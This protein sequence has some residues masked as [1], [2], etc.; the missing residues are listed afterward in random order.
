MHSPRLGAHI[1]LLGSALFV[2]LVSI[3][4]ESPLST[5]SG[6][7]FT[8]PPEFRS[9]WRSVEACGGSTGDFDSLEW[10]VT[11]GSAGARG[12]T[13]IAGSYWPD[14]HRIYISANFLNDQQLIRHEMLHALLGGEEH[15]PQFLNECGGIVSCI[16]NCIEEAGGQSALP[17]PTSD[18]ILPSALEVTVSV[19]QPEP[20]DAGWATVVVSARNTSLAPVWVDLTARPGVQFECL[21]N[22]FRCGVFYSGFSSPQPFRAGE[23]RRE[24]TVFSSLPGNY[25]IVGLYNTE[26]SAPS[27]LV[28]P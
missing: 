1:A 5:P 21:K 15:E 2:A 26:Q 19:I 10:Y 27:S 11:A 20:G 7:P 13:A 24:A 3:A 8:P 28:V 23:T 16:A 6:T 12:D 14:L 17:S 25:E 18:T 9:M 22:T 4:C